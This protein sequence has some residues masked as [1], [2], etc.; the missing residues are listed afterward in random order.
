MQKN[1]NNNN[2]KTLHLGISFAN[3]R[4]SKMKQKSWKKPEGEKQLSYRKTSLQKPSKQEKSGME[5]LKCWQKNATNLEFC[6]LQ[7]YPSD[8]TE[9]GGNVLV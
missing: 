4:K 6:T 2:N 3:Y 5:H 9:T 8:V 1:I 7:N